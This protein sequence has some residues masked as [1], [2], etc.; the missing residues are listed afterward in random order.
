MAV[1]AGG[2]SVLV[3]PD[4][5]PGDAGKGGLEKGVQQ[6]A[7]VHG[8]HSLTEPSVSGTQTAVHVVEAVCH[9]VDGIDDEAHLAVLDV[10][11]LQTLVAYRY[12]GDIMVL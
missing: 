8:V 7:A 5:F 10:V 1:P 11:V 12:N 4:V 3:E 6:L 2:V 9:G